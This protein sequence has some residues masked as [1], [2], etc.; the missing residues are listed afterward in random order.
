MKLSDPSGLTLST[1]D[2][3]VGLNFGVPLVYGISEKALVVLQ[4]GLGLGL[5]KGKDITTFS[6]SLGLIIALTKPRVS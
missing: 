5:A 2:G 3:V 6:V 1:T 4:P